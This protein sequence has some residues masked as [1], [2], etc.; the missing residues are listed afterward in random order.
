[1]TNEKLEVP[2]IHASCGG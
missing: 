1:M 2:A